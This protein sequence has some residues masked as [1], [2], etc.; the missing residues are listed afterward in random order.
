MRRMKITIVG[1]YN[2][3]ETLFDRL[4]LPDGLLP[5]TL[6]G[7][8]LR[9]CGDLGLTYPDW[10]WMYRWIGEWSE[11]NQYKW[12][13]LAASMNFDYDPIQNYNRTTESTISDE[14]ANRNLNATTRTS[15]GE[16]DTDVKDKVAAF[17]EVEPKLKNNV[18]TELDYEDVSMV[19]GWGIETRGNQRKVTEKSSGNIGV[20]TSQRMLELER[21][22]ADFNLYEQIAM[23]FKRTFCIMV[24]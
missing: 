18:I 12:K 5:E 21:G 8:I 13:T 17:N 7:Y 15:Y 4:S 10:E 24:Y 23:E 3:D 19:D 2:Y 22:I 11:G 14:G 20:T 1:M 9:E 6:I 16:N